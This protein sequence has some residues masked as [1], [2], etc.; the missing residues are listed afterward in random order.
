V[1]TD[2]P[3]MPHFQLVTTDGTALGA[4]EARPPRLA[5]RLSDLRRPGRGEPARRRHARSRER[6]LG[7]ALQ[8]ACRRRGL[9]QAL[10]RRQEYSDPEGGRAGGNRPARW[11]AARREAPGLDR[12]PGG[13]SKPAVPAA[14]RRQESCCGPRCGPLIVRNVRSCADPCGRR[15]R[16]ETRRNPFGGAEMALLLPP[17]AFRLKTYKTREPRLRH[18][19][20]SLWSGGAPPEVPRRRWLC[21]PAT[22]PVGASALPS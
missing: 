13:G 6:G 14:G 19:G 3:P 10:P 22:L 16:P 12:A 8:G 7:D 9:V 21:G 2:G 20:L 17:W 15:Q 11:G 1:Y 18:P 4:R 5:T